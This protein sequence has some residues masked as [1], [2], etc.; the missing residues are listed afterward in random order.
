MVSLPQKRAREW[1]FPKRKDY[2]VDWGQKL[3]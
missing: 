3:K 2:R 1:L